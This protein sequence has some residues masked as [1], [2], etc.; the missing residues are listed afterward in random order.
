MFFLFMIFSALAWALS[1]MRELVSVFLHFL[2][3]GVLPS[4]QSLS[5]RTMSLPSL[6]F[7]SLLSLRLTRPLPF[8]SLLSLR[9]TRDF[10]ETEVPSDFLDPAELEV[11]TDMFMRDLPETEV[12]A[13]FLDPAELEVP[14]D[15]FMRDLPELEVPVDFLEPAELEVPTDMFSMER[16]ELESSIEKMERFSMELEVPLDLF[17]LLEVPIDLLMFM[18][19][20]PDL[21][22][23]DFLETEETDL[24]DFFPKRPK[25]ERFS[26]ESLEVPTDLMDPAELEVPMDM[27]MRD[28]P[29]LEE[30]DFLEMEETD[31]LETDSDFFPKRVSQKESFWRDFL[32]ETDLM[33]FLSET[34][35]RLRRMTLTED[36]EEEDLFFKAFLAFL[37]I[38][39]IFLVERFLRDGGESDLRDFLD[40]G[41]RERFLRDL[42]LDLLESDFLDGG[43]RE[44][45]L[46]DLELDLLALR[47]LRDLEL[48]LLAF[49]AFLTF[50]VE[51][52]LRDGGETDFLESDF[53]DG[54]ERERF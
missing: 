31:F 18:R 23:T 21:E 17:P 8:L 40:G 25:K 22:E 54:G 6:P 28:L 1:C 46:R 35:S 36:L 33:D 16:R 10:P 49:L 26:T 12:P 4:L 51:R 34:S 30:T 15:M 3:L 44:R 41:E 47:F 50:L 37:M 42:E 52:F 9:L 32:E 48:D 19:D 29:D 43:E 24:A 13:D 45:F 53:L 27:F 5:R 7:L 14:T 38:L 39:A 20:L 2:P 11:P